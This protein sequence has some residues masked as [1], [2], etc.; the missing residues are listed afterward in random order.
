MDGDWVRVSKAVKEIAMEHVGKIKCTKKRWYNEECRQAVER[1]RI[2]REK[3]IRVDSIDSIDTRELYTLER[4]N[5]KR[6]MQREKRKYLNEILKEAEKNHS[7][8]K[9]RHIFR[10]IKQYKS[11]NSS[12]KIIRNCN[13]E[14]IMDP[15]ERAARWKEYF[16]ELLNADIPDNTMRRET[17]YGADP[18][19]SEVTEEETSR[20]GN[21]QD[22]ME[23]QVSSLNTVEKKCIISCLEYVGR[24]GK[25]NT[26]Q[27]LGMKL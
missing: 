13:N 14:L 15:K 1:R 23:Y 21:R 11:F 19:I 3:F 16:I 22:L 26:C 27:Q 5:C 12:L 8:G 2:V 17:H 6:I 10:T 25:T 7:R 4:K 24:Y 9:T 20:I 18:M